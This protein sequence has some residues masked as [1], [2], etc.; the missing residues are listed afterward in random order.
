M[1]V[2][3]EENVNSPMNRPTIDP[4][5]RD[6]LPPHTSEEAERLA[7][8]LKSEKFRDKLVVWKEENILLDGHNRLRICEENGIAYQIDYLS[9][10]DRESAIAWIVEHQLARRNLTTRQRNY[11]I[12]KKYN[13]NKQ[14]HGG[15]RRSDQVSQNGTSFGSTAEQIAKEQGVS[16]SVVRQNAV[17]AEAVDALP[18][19]E[20]QA[21]LNGQSGKT[22]KQIIKEHGDAYEG[23]IFCGRCAR[24]GATPN[25]PKCVE[26]RAKDARRATNG[27]RTRK[28]KNGRVD[29]DY[30]PVKKAVGAFITSVDA[31]GKAYGAK[32]SVKAEALRKQAYALY[33]GIEAWHKE[34]KQ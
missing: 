6:F 21:H 10:P 12:G 13:A 32:E 11:F 28:P 29:F 31:L 7:A 33:E 23:P 2:R 15:D 14:T 18:P 30:K 20:R 24:V 16:P 9:F 22:K 19:A 26:A 4:E 8:K 1:V 5:I 34:L 27:T 17:Y 25:C 3:T